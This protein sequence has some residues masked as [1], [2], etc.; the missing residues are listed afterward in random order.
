MFVRQHEV[1]ELHLFKFQEFQLG[2]MSVS[3]SVE[4]LI[5]EMDAC[6]QLTNLLCI[7]CCF[8]VPAVTSAFDDA[9]ILRARALIT[10]VMADLM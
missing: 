5:T 8:L 7:I 3:C 1:A 10:E 4:L 9:S 2:G 6:A